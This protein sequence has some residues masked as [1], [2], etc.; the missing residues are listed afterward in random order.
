MKNNILRTL[1]IAC[2]FILSGCGGPP[3]D[4]ITQAILLDGA[5]KSGITQ[6]FFVEGVNEGS[7]SI[8]KQEITNSWTEEIEKEKV[9][10]YEYDLEFE[11]L[12]HKGLLRKGL[13]RNPTGRVSIVQK[14]EKWYVYK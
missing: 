8:V 3:D 1:I 13:K 2:L 14:G 9:Y 5:K 6:S 4:A 11:F 10:F 7:I 12:Q